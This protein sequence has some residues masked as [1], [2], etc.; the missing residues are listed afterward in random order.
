MR[1]SWIFGAFIT[2]IIGLILTL[3]IIGSVIGVPL[4]V[5]SVVLLILGI[6]I[7]GQKKEVH[8]VHHKK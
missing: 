7:P 2:F 4:I 8:H 3:T 1:T 5:L 6:I